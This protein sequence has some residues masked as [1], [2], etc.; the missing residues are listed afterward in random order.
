[1]P[2]STRTKSESKS[3]EDL[4]A[5]LDA[6]PVVAPLET[7][8]SSSNMSD[9]KHIYKRT[10]SNSQSSNSSVP[11]P[12]Y[13]Q[14]PILNKN[15]IS[16][17]KYSRNL[18]SRGLPKKGGGGGKHT[19]GA[20]GCELMVDDVDHNDPNYDS[21]D[22]E[23]VVMVCVEGVGVKRAEASVQSPRKVRR[24]LEAENFDT[25]IK[26]ILSEYFLN[27]DSMEVIAVL[28]NF[29][30]EAIKSHLIAYTIQVAIERNHVC[31]ELTSRLLRDFNME[32]FESINFENAFDNLF[33][34]INELILD[35]PDVTKT[36][37]TF[38]ARSIADK[39][40]SKEFITNSYVKYESNDLVCEIICHAKV[41]TN[42][43]DHLFHLS[44]IWCH[45]NGGFTAVKDLTDKI[46]LLIQEYYDS[47]D[48]NEA[49]RCLKELNVP[50]FHHEFVFEALDFA[51]QK[52]DNY[53]IE[54]IINL[55]KTLCD[56][57]VITLDQLKIGF[58]RIHDILS[59]ISLDVPNASQLMLK[60]LS[61]CE[62]KGIITGDIK[63]IFAQK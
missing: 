16:S 1:M 61:L 20:P 49:V 60:I 47:G 7:S 40:T 10:H 14:D 63:E 3:I 23:N 43:N 18:K 21:E 32:L 36:I 35:N 5:Q 30:F 55:L 48:V 22:S 45:N 57:V 9:K 52:G 11:Q 4:I 27:G 53:A 2:L 33:K 41:L 37:G 24:Q 26:P 13:S 19:W 59:D 28:K 15:I 8:N 17:K 56:S 51:L 38:I 58:N 44:H 29:D 34:N 50:H 54:L 62:A 39:V 42:M 31:K 6:P 25:N 12:S 46:N